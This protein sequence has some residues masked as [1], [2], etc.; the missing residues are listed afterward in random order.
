MVI[1]FGFSDI[2]SYHVNTYLVNFSRIKCQRIRNLL[3][4]IKSSS[5]IFKSFIHFIVSVVDFINSLISKISKII[6]KF[7]KCFLLCKPVVI[8]FSCMLATLSESGNHLSIF[9]FSFR[10]YR[11]LILDLFIDIV[12]LF[13]IIFLRIYGVLSLSFPNFKFKVELFGIK[14]GSFKFFF[15][16]LFNFFCLVFSS[17]F[18]RF[19]FLY[20]FGSA[21]GE[22]CSSLNTGRFKLR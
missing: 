16:F 8:S 3:L 1:V 7:G 13:Y 19:F 21:S 17:F 18:W 11:R 20:S 15:E 4:K 2:S 14:L 12:F 5:S 9:F 6:S 22:I 10:R